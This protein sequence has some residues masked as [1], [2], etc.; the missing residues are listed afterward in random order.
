MSLNIADEAGLR[1]AYADFAIRFG[2]EMTAV[3]V[4]RMV[5][6]VSR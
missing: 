4:Q 5:P 2:S 3:L 6:R 1:A